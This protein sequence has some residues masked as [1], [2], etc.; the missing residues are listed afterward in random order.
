MKLFKYLSIAALALVAVACSDDDDAPQVKSP[1]IYFGEDNTTNVM[2]SPVE[3]APTSFNVYIWR[4]EKGQAQTVDVTY[5]PEAEGLF[6]VPAQATFAADSYKAT[7][8]VD[9]D[10]AQWS[11]GQ[12]KSLKLQLGG[13]YI[14]DYAYAGE[15]DVDVTLYYTFKSLGKGMMVDNW[16]SVLFSDLEQA[17]PYS[18]EIQEAEQLPGLYRLVNPFGSSFCAGVNQANPGQNFK[19]AYDESKITYYLEVH[20]EDPNFFYMLPQPASGN[21]WYSRFSQVVGTYPGMVMAQGNSVADVKA[22]LPQYFAKLENGTVTM[23]AAT[24]RFFYTNSGNELTNNGNGY[25]NVS[26]P[27][28]MFTMP[29]VGVS[30]YSVGL[31]YIGVLAVDKK[32]NEVMIGQTFGENVMYAKYAMEKTADGDALCDGI[33]DGTVEANWIEDLTAPYLRI[34]VKEDGTYTVGVITYGEDNEVAKDRGSVTFKVTLGAGGVTEGMEEWGQGIMIDG[35]VIAAFKNSA[36]NEGFVAYDYRYLVP[37]YRG[38]ANPKIYGLYCPYGNDV[39][40]SKD[41]KGQYVTVFGNTSGDAE[42][43]V[44]IDATNPSFIKIAPQFSGFTRAG[45]GEMFIANVEGLLASDPESTDAENIAYMQENDLPFTT[46][47]SG[48][49]DIPEPRF[50]RTEA[51]NDKWYMWQNSQNSGVWLPGSFQMGV[52]ALLKTTRTDLAPAAT[53]MAKAVV[54]VRKSFVGKPYVKIK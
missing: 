8:V 5:V 31:A 29:G 39:F 27:S 7:I 1:G 46:E 40:Q 47:K 30:D 42:V 6:T 11:I 17:A 33:E 35:W 45:W 43:M 50:T 32:G 4:T 36:T 26:T 16:I 18:V 9:C 14:S 2:L 49:I 19:A 53:Q 41:G 28:V 38:T 34:P 24:A 13:Q 54:S 25:S 37:V 15:M 51:D 21:P 22:A 23:P 20:G 44:K 10:V 3:G 12:T 48:T 52:S